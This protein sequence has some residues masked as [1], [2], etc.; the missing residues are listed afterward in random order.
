MMATTLVAMVATLSVLLSLVSFAL[1]EG[2]KEA[3]SAQRFVETVSILA[4]CFVTMETSSTEMGK[5]SR[6]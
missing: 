5:Y 4:S 2:F 1:R 6:I 3:T